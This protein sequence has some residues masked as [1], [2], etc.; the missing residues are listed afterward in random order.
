MATSS[1]P[2]P[3]KSAVIMGVGNFAG[4]VNVSPNCCFTSAVSWAGSAPGA[5][6]GWLICGDCAAG[7]QAARNRTLPRNFIRKVYSFWACRRWELKIRILLANSC[8][9]LFAGHPRMPYGDGGPAGQR[10]E[11]QHHD[12]QRQAE[13]HAKNQEHKRRQ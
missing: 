11:Q 5:A 3:S 13:V 4:T 6:V 10:G 1:T 7:T 2:S 12:G 8:Q 9:A